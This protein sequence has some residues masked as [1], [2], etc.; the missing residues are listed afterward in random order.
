MIGTNEE[1]M[2]IEKMHDEKG[3]K[4]APNELYVALFHSK[5][6]HVLNVKLS[7]FLPSCSSLLLLRFICYYGSFIEGTNV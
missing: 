4:W 7:L 5:Y 6:V 2:K 1:G 3:L